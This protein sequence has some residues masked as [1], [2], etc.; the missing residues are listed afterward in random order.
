MH[1]FALESTIDR[2]PRKTLNSKNCRKGTV[3]KGIFIRTHAT[4]LVNDS[5]RPT[6]HVQPN[7]NSKKEA[8]FSSTGKW[9]YLLK[10][11]LSKLSKFAQNYRLNVLLGILNPRGQAMKNHSYT[12]T[13]SGSET[14]DSF[15]ASLVALGFEQAENQSFEW[16]SSYTSTQ[17]LLQAIS[18]SFSKECVLT[19]SEAD[20]YRLLRDTVNIP[21]SVLYE[22]AELLTSE[23]KLSSLEEEKKLLLDTAKQRLELL[24]KQEEI[25]RDAVSQQRKRV[26]AAVSPQSMRSRLSRLV[27]PDSS[28]SESSDS[29]ADELKDVF[30]AISNPQ[31][32]DPNVDTY[33]EKER[34]FSEELLASA[35]QVLFEKEVDISSTSSSPEELPVRALV[36]SYGDIKAN[37]CIYEAR[38]AKNN[39]VLAALNQDKFVFLETSCSSMNALIKDLQVRG[40]KAMETR[41]KHVS[42]QARDSLWARLEEIRHEEMLSRQTTIIDFMQLSAQLC[43]QQ[44]MRLVCFRLVVSRQEELYQ[45]LLD[46]LR[47]LAPDAPS[48]AHA[49]LSC[50]TSPSRSSGGSCST[51]TSD[52]LDLTNR[53]TTTHQSSVSTSCKVT[54]ESIGR[55]TFTLRVQQLAETLEDFLSTTICK[56]GIPRFE[57]HQDYLP[58][59]EKVEKVLA[60]NTSVLNAVLRKR[61]A[62]VAISAAAEDWAKLVATLAGRQKMISEY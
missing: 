19:R 14:N 45:S 24:R 28:D 4:H 29:V 6:S 48:E 38:L 20:E 62:P 55:K 51:K 18:T 21:D 15:S 32:L 3:L 9:N 52:Q 58:L 57:S 56:D 1:Q 16:L 7:V 37:Q 26:R 33:I 34:A 17:P 43:F 40:K 44:R 23:P 46:K 59:V 54:M 10:G 11:K 60:R 50:L 53:E 27:Q 36:Q 22:T 42:E 8:F 12:S 5:A 25:L 31:N 13:I 39:A 49:A 2:F 35:K 41:S 30:Q 61:K 47:N